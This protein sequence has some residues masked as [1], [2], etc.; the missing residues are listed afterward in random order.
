MFSK[1]MARCRNILTSRAQAHRRTSRIRSFQSSFSVGVQ[2]LEPRLLLT[3]AEFADPHPAAGNQFGDSV[4]VLTNGNVVITSPN[5]DA[6]G[7]NAGAVYLFNGQTG[8][9]I[10]TVLGSHAGDSIGSRDVIALSNGNFVFI[11]PSWDN[12][13][14]TDA[15]AVTFGNGTTGVSGTVS[16]SNSLVGSHS[17]DM[18]SALIMPLSTGNYVVS[19]PDW[20]NGTVVDAGAVTFGNGTVGIVGVVSAGNSLAGSHADDKVG[21]GGITLLTNGNYVVSSPDWDNGSIVDAG[22]ATL[23][24]GSTAIAG[25][26]TSTN[27]LVGSHPNDAVSRYALH[28]RGVT[29]LSNGNYIVASP[30]W[31]NG[32]VVDAGAV[33]FGNGTTGIKGTVSAS[34]SLVGTQDDDSVGGD[35][36]YGAY[37]FLGG[38]TALTNGNYLVASPGWNNGGIGNAGAV[39]FGNGSAGVVG[40]INV[41]N[42]LVGSQAD[43][44][45]G[46]TLETEFTPMHAVTALT[47][48]NYVVGSPMWD[49]GGVSDAGAATFGNG[50][51]GVKGTISDTN[52]LVG[53]QAGDSIGGTYVLFDL[54]VTGGIT[55]LTNGNYVVASPAWSNGSAQGAGAVTWGS[56]STGITGAV[57]TTNSLV[58]TQTAHLVG[59]GA[60]SVEGNERA[61][62]PLANGNY[63]VTSILWSN[64]SAKGAGAV[65]FG[66]GT[67]GVAGSVSAANSLVGTQQSDGVGAGGIRALSTGNYVVSSP[68][69]NSGTLQHAGAATLGSGLT[70]I[71]GAVSSANS[72]VGNH[73]EDLLAIGGITALTNGNYLIY[74][75]RWNHDSG[76]LTFGNGNVGVNA[77]VITPNNSRTGIKFDDLD[78]THISVIPLSNGNFVVN[79]LS[80]AGQDSNEGVVIFEDGLTSLQDTLAPSRYII[81]A[82][83]GAGFDTFVV[84]DPSHSAFYASFPTDGSGHVY[85]GSAVTGFALPP[86]SISLS[87]NTV[88]EQQPVGRTVGTFSATDPNPGSSITYS[89]VSGSG[90]AD[91]PK[92]TIVNGAT[93]TLKTAA[94][95]D[96]NTKQSYS[97]RVR[98]TDSDGLFTEQV[99]TVNV[100]GVNQAPTNILLSSN[101]VAEHQPFGTIGHFSTVDPDSGNTFQYFL[102]FHD[103]GDNN[104]FFL[105]EDGTL[106]GSGFDFKDKSTYIITVYSYDQD[107]LFITKDFTIHVTDVAIPPTNIELSS[108]TV[109]EKKLAGTIV[110][111]FTTTDAEYYSTFAYTLG[112]GGDNAAFTID[113]QGFLRTNS[114]LDAAVQNSYTISVTSTDDSNLSITEFFTITVT[115][116]AAGGATELPDPN[117]FEGNQFG[118]SVTVLPNG[119]VVVTSAYDDLGGTDAGA[120]YLYNG[121]TGA[122]ISSLTGSHVNDHVGMDGITVLS[123]G[124]FLVRSAFWNTVGAVTFVNGTTGLNGVVSASNSLLGS[125][126]SDQLGSSGVVALPNG[127]YVISSYE[128]N[129]GALNNAGAVTFGNGTTGVSGIITSSNSLVGM[130]ANDFVG[131]GGIAVLTNGNYV[132]TSGSW[133]NGAVTNVG[134]VTFASGTTGITGTISTANSLIGSQTNDVVGT[135]FGGRNGVIALKNGNYVVASSDWDNGPT[136]NAGAVTFGNGTTGVK[137]TISSANSLVGTVAGDRVGYDGVTVLD[138]GNYVVRSTQ[139]H[140]GALADAGAVTF[141]NGT[142]GVSGNVSATNSLV[143]SQAGDRLGNGGITVLSSG[144]YVVVSSSWNNGAVVNAGAVTFG[145]KTAGVI[146]TVS[147]GNSLVGNQT[148]DSVGGGGVTVLSNGNYVVASPVWNNGATADAG[149]VTFGNGATGLFGTVSGANSLVGTQ[150]NDKVGS[151][152]ATALTNG[153]FV[154]KSRF[155]D[156]GSVVDAGA[157]TF[158]NGVTGLTGAVTAANSLTG[159]H[160]NDFVGLYGVVAL[161]NGNYVVSSPEWDNDANVNAG[162]ATFGNGA[163]GVSGLVTAS[164]SLVGTQ[165]NDYVGYAEMKALSN[166][167]YVVSSP[168]WNNGSVEGAG[169]VTFGNGTTGISGAV[170]AANSLVGSHALDGVGGAGIT[171]L[172]SGNYVVGSSLWDNGNVIEAGAVTFGDGTVGIS[173][174]VSSTNSLVGTLESNGVG[175]NVTSLS[176]GSYLVLSFYLDNVAAVNKV[177]VSFGSSVTGVNGPLNLDNS[178][179]APLPPSPALNSFVVEDA[180]HSALY[181]SIPNDDSGHVY[182]GSTTSGLFKSPPTSIALAGNII[183]ELPIVGTSVGTFSTVDPDSGNTFTYSFVSGNGSDDNSK[184]SISGGNLLTAGT[185]D[186]ETNAFAS[187]RVRSTDQSGLFTEQ[188]FTI[189]LVNQNEAPTALALTNSVIAENQTAPTTVGSFITTDPD[190]GNTFSYTLVSGNGSTDNSSFTVDSS[191]H[192]R[193]ASNFNFETKNSYTIRVRVADQGGLS[194]ESPFTIT[195]ANVNEAPT[196]LSLSALS[197]AEN[198]A[199]GATIGTLT[200]TDP[201]AGSTFTFNLVTGPGGDDNDSFD[202]TDNVLTINSPV[203]FETR[204]SYTIRIRATDLDGLTF[205]KTFTITVTNSNEAPTDLAVSANSIAENNAANA[206]IGT[207]S[208]IDPDG[209][210]T[211]TFSLVTG[212]GSTDNGSFSITGNTLK[213]I[214]STDFETQSSYSIRIRATDQGGLTFERPLTIN[215]NLV[216]LAPTDL[217]VSTTSIAEN[218]ATNA[219]VGT[220]SANDPNAGDIFAYSLIAGVGSDDNASFTI[221]GNALTIN[222]VANFEAKNSYSVRIRVTDQGGL[223]FEKPI[224]ISVTNLNETPTDVA[225]S[226]SSIAEHNAANAPVGTLNAIDPDTGSTFTFSLVA[227]IGS[228]DNGSFSILNNTLSIIPSTSFDT[229][230]SYAIRIAATDPGGLSFEKQFTITVTPVNQAPT[231]LTLSV[232]TIAENN[233]ANATV[234]MLSA[235]DPNS[236]ESLTFSLVAGIGSTDNASFAISNNTLQVIPTTNF[237]TKASYAI[238]VQVIDQEGLTFE[239]PLTIAV[240]DVNE[241]P[242]DISLSVSSIAENNVPNAAVGMLGAVDPDSG[243]TFTFSLVA[244]VGGTDNASFAISNIALKIIPSADFETK[245]SYSIRVKV[246]DQDGLTF[247]KP[248]TITVTDVAET[249]PPTLSSDSVAVVSNKATRIVKVLPLIVVGGTSLGGGTLTISLNSPGKKKPTDTLKFPSTLGTIP[250]PTKIGSQF[251]WQ[252]QLNTNVTAA[253][254]QSFLRGLTFST[255]GGGLGVPSRLLQVT[256]SNTSQQNAPFN[257][258]IT[259]IKK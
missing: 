256:L 163:T 9:L 215:V 93:R 227:G 32:N 109:A 185:F 156:N 196:G 194:F 27:S 150:A 130:K 157:V 145:S 74:S 17:G 64:G 56:G 188:I 204:A 105:L 182:V 237:E 169:A 94:V 33:T 29:A 134:A 239:K 135:R 102:E 83:P 37:N 51:T 14:V 161:T 244:G 31:D 124:N 253:T 205:E 216:N 71:S 119:N 21:N 57:T 87:S 149:A 148:D 10:S 160:N 68:V 63:V 165:T 199:A 8:A 96:F 84:P 200:A 24:N 48:G 152:G 92:F 228:N 254:I 212:A 192:L 80:Y 210:G 178:L 100:T 131:G 6:G 62:T 129:N 203:D 103:F 186:Y 242:S 168:Y 208:A 49:N 78:H 230:N 50:T 187:I 223:T 144:N 116:V 125:T 177:A 184:F 191:G 189:G 248:L 13:A 104:K 143:G 55:A 23:C 201:D 252:F 108:S 133:D 127:N 141:G 34:N 35:V 231:D 229:K 240:T 214:P 114:P 79:A 206:I 61:V 218:N 88:S 113:S 5:D 207:L 1:W 73:P 69:W 3:A 123:N 138:N 82:S 195:V 158:G 72:L 183:G 151:E 11:S 22:A 217:L 101:T 60:E 107:G 15:G 99:F 91:N 245:N 53:T 52:S 97:I 250:A 238:R 198:N 167:N 164:N 67:T 118:S 111:K 257:Q 28:N 122:L 90:S 222:P 40:A 120:V 209:T 20:D 213:V 142:T 58:G 18:N 112:A 45:V 180:T 2:L 86:T 44:M 137:G 258:S 232:N 246:T 76:A 179:A 174:V 181:L 159:S 43:D 219:T 70:G 26:V 126:G 236:G 166:G 77:A 146:G 147:A 249:V 132:I 171:A 30:S 95:F 110:G 98:A 4:T 59:G 175:T 233:A 41:T 220:L 42:S 193:T 170:S 54:F 85:R 139:W 226:A 47:N 155:W 12:G 211:F 234:G 251:V 128:W 121:Q 19:S 65:T 190:A 176:N 38:I 39:T 172:S 241:A 259:V 173:G 25:A 247:E 106:Q 46:G 243:N 115:P 154:V 81:G 255:K 162:A 221:S 225:L 117:A 75:R 16:V 36:D 202:I 66:N 153:N 224:T 235:T 197:I 140:N 89:L 136:A 7:N